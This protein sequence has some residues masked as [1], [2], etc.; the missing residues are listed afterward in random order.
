MEIKLKKVNYTSSKHTINN[1]LEIQDLNLTIKSNKITSF[2]GA[3]GAG[4]TTI[5]K[6]VALLTRATSGEIYFGNTKVTRKTNKEILNNLRSQIGVV[7][8]HA[9]EHFIC[10]TVKEEIEYAINHSNYKTKNLEK[11]VQDSLRI[12]G[13]NNSHLNRKINSLSKGEQKKLSIAV[14]L[15]YNPKIIILDEPSLELD[16]NAKKQLIKIIRLMKLRYKKTII[17]FSKDTDFLHSISDYIYIINQGQIVSQGNKYEVFTD[18]NLLKQ[19]A[20]AVP[21][22]IEIPYLVESKKNVKIGYRD[23]I[24]DLMKDIYRYVR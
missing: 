6:L 10:K 13:L 16:S 5:L 23:D 9:N 17:V 14:M 2:V 18:V 11:R 24:N 20:L 7:Y 21:K 19:N 15:S 8:Q 22:V 4:K 3:S 12:I 1:K